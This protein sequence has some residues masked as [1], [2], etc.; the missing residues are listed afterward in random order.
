MCEERKW[1]AAAARL[2][3]EALESDPKLGDAIQGRTRHQ[4]AGLAVLAGVGQ[5]EDDPRP[6]EAAR[7]RW[8]AQARDWFRADLRL[9]ANKVESGNASDCG[10][11]VAHLQHWKVCPNL[12]PV[13]GPEARKNLPEAER[14]EW[15]ALW[16]EVEALLKQAEDRHKQLTQ[17][18]EKADELAVRGQS[19]LAEKKWAEAEPLIRQCLATREKMQPDA[20]ST[21]H[22]K[23]MLGGALLGQKKY[24]EAEPLLLVGYEGMKR[25]ERSIPPDGKIRLP[26]AVERLVQLYEALDKKD[27]VARWTR[28]RAAIKAPAQ[29]PK[30]ENA[31][32]AKP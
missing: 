16:G 27:E 10:A 4:A 20:W 8:R 17:A 30:K 31:K 26:Q 3:A 24:A 14:Q 5:G 7:K 32:E 6:D 21:F 25:R 23:S 12:A 18:D 1:L 28:E 29:K 15:Q 13:R 2:T 19:L 9:C 22:A 11:V